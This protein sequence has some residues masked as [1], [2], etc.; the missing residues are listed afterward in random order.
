MSAN[1]FETSVASTLETLRLLFKIY[2]K[3]ATIVLGFT[4]DN[5]FHM[6]TGDAF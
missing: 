2:T 3:T 1:A 4:Q 6:N 5:A